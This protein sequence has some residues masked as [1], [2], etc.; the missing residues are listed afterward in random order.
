MARPIDLSPRREFVLPSERSLPIDQQTT[1]I[2]KPLSS[3]D[4]LLVDEWL[5]PTP[6]REAQPTRY[7]LEFLRRSLAGWRNF[8]TGKQPGEK[9]LEFTCS[10]ADGL[11]TDE[12]LGAIP[13]ELIGALLAGAREAMQALDEEQR[14]KS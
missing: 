13:V 4:R 8:P 9:D 7:A 2:F 10:R 3:V 11:P 14:G 12:T 6:D 5:R 1:W